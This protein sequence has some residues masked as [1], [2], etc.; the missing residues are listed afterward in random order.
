MAQ[1]SDVL[2]PFQ[3][4]WCSGIIVASHA[5]DRGSIP[6]WRTTLPFRYEFLP[7]PENSAVL[8]WWTIPSWRSAAD[9]HLLADSRPA[10]LT[11]PADCH[12]ELARHPTK[13]CCGTASRHV[14]CAYSIVPIHWCDAQ[15][16][17]TAMMALLV[18]HPV[19]MCAHLYGCRDL[20]PSHLAAISPQ[21]TSGRS[22]PI[23]QS[24]K[25]GQVDAC[26]QA[27]CSACRQCTLKLCGVCHTCMLQ[28][29]LFDQ[30]R[31]YCT[32]QQACKVK[33][34]AGNIRGARGMGQEAKRVGRGASGLVQIM[35]GK[36]LTAV[37]SGTGRSPTA[38]CTVTS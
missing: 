23:D 5:T 7:R 16:I 2:Q 31:T 20:A 19:H 15:T 24:W 22:I 33:G 10:R 35:S 28:R 25:G 13:S 3:R 9:P 11:V 21:L 37:A 27:S 29:T 38:Y 18:N 8:V 32:D 1:N 14:N 30:R 4:Q 34:H 36:P 6:R 12:G 26:M 17:S